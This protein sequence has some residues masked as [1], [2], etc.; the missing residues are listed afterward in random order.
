[1]TFN[2]I[3]AVEI[4]AIVGIEIDFGGKTEKWLIHYRVRNNEKS[5]LIL[6]F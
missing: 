4:E 6:E 3:L 1:M 2:N 5:V